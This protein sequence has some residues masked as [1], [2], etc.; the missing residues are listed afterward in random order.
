T[1]AHELFWYVK[2]DSKVRSLADADGKTIAF[3]APGS[4][5]NLILLSLLEGAGSKAKPVATGGL[6][7]TLTQVMT[8]QIDIG[9]AVP[10]FALRELQENKIR[11]IA[12]AREATELRNQTIRV[13]IVNVEAQKNKR[14]AITRLMQVYDKAIDWSYANP[15][16]IDFFAE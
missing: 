6:P 15:K 11:I 5:S 13:N 3:S 9:W 1:G 8:G 16:A 7:A 10:P 2:P 4:S 14:A 12:R